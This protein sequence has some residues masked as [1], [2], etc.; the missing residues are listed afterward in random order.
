MISITECR[1]QCNLES[2]E[3]DF[4]PWFN[5]VIPAAIIV[6]ETLTFRK[7]YK[8]QE[9]V[10]ASEDESASLFDEGLKLGALML[11]GHWFLNRETT[12]V[13]NLNETP[14]ALEYLVLPYRR[15]DSLS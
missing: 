11:I 14:M 13:L 15:M 1:R 9:E 12:T 4:D 8:T 2:D 5:Q 6:I 10:D 3:V 7:F